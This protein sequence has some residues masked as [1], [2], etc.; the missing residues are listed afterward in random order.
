MMNTLFR[1]TALAGTLL[2]IPACTQTTPAEPTEA[3]IVEQA[4]APLFDGMGDYT[5]SISTSNPYVQRYFNQGMVM[6]FGFNHAEAIRSF[7]A[8]QALDPDCAMCFWGEALAT[9]PNINVTANGKPVMTEAEQIAAYDALQRALELAPDAPQIEQ[10][11][12]A[13]LANR[14]TEEP[15]D[16]RTQIDIR[17]ARAMGELKASYPDDDDIA[18]MYAEAWMNTMPWDYWSDGSTPRPEAEQAIEALETVLARSPDHP[19]AIHLYIHAVEA[20]D[21]PG[22]AEAAAD[23]LVTLVPASGHLVHMP[24]HIYWRIGRYDDAARVNIM[25]AEVDE[26]YIAAC[27]A[28]GFYPAAYY[29]HNIHFLWAAASMAGQSELAIE[30]GEKVASFVR[31]EDIDQFPTVELFHTVPLLTRV[32]FGHWDYLLD[33]PQPRADLGFSNAI[34]RYARGTALARTGD[35]QAAQAER[36][37]L[38]PLKD[39]DRVLY[40]DGVDYPASLLINIAD[41]LLEGEIAMANGETDTAIAAFESA[42]ALQDTLPYMEPPF[43]YYPTRQSLGE[44]FMAADRFTDAEAI[45]RRDLELFPRNGWSTFGLIA[46]LSA[47][48]RSEEATELQSRFD[49]IWSNADVTLTGSRL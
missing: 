12:I 37:A 24:S 36:D 1:A 11:M 5:R 42:V 15:V 17:Y 28:Q 8:A 18:A 4:G 40:L 13:A 46:A 14:Y 38:A 26:A 21:N 34:W 43:W 2:I 41:H 33:T 16:D 45:Y 25:A 6:A 27:N 31:L 29:P 20:S 49:Q 19:L 10:D 35:P 9:G 44:A 7:R 23:R 47:Q 22:R 39:N 32:Q 48:G 3:A 30:S